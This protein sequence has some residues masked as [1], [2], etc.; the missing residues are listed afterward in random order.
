MGAT[1]LLY[2]CYI[3]ALSTTILAPTISTMKTGN[4]VQQPADILG[5]DS[6]ENK[7]LNEIDQL[8][9]SQIGVQFLRCNCCGTKTRYD[10]YGTVCRRYCFK[11]YRVQNP[12]D[13]NNKIVIYA[14]CTLQKDYNI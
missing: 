12:D 13:Q 3:S 4:S 7:R 6:P 1:Y 10:E 5:D 11:R 8:C 2:I 14:N 9:R